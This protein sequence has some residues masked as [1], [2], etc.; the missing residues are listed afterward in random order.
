MLYIVSEAHYNVTLSGA[1]LHAAIIMD[2]TLQSSLGADWSFVF[3]LRTNLRGGDFAVI[4]TEPSNLLNIMI[5]IQKIRST[6][7]Q[8]RCCFLCH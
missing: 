1:L 6:F 4:K 7:L 5:T 8:L 2:E 3:P